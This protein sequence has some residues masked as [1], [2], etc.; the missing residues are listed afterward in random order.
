MPA[1]RFL[2]TLVVIV[3][4]V[5]AVV[6]C[7]DEARKPSIHDW[8]EDSRAAVA[9]NPPDSDVMQIDPSASCE[10]IDEFSVDGK[11][12]ELFGAGTAL[13]GDIGTRYQCA[14]SGDTNGSANVRL[15]VVMIDNAN[16][17]DDYAAL[18]PTRDGNTVVVTPIG[19]VQ[20]ASV[21]PAGSTRPLTTSVLVR[22]DEQG[23]VHL[24]VELLIDAEW[25]PDQ[26]AELLAR[27]APTIDP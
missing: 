2:L 25:T 26:H 8:F 9:T 19:D 12:A 4:A 11:R 13:F 20:V 7:A 6:S 15:E 18:I 16:D 23:G 10:L 27:L 17:F 1:R 24:V 14:W 22:D 3:I 21:V 5:V